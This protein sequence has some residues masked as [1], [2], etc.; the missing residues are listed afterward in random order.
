MLLEHAAWDSIGMKLSEELDE[1]PHTTTVEG[2]Q[3]RFCPVCEHIVEGSISKE[4]VVN[5]FTELLEEILEEEVEEEV[6]EP[7]KPSSNT[8]EVTITVKTNG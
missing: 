8:G 7:E 6:A 1:Y 5:I 4:A 2:E 3:P